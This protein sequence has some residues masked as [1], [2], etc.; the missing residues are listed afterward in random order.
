MSANGDALQL[1]FPIELGGDHDADLEV[2]ARS[3]DT[4]QSSSEQLLIEMFPDQTSALLADW[5]RVLNITPGPDDPVQL[6]RDRI[7][8]MLRAK[9]GL[10][11]SYF[12]GLAQTLG[13]EIEIEEPV[14]FMAGWGTAGDDIFASA[15]IS[16]WGVIIKNQP[17]YAFLAGESVAGESLCWWNPQAFLEDLI[18]ELKPAHTTVYFIYV[19]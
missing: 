5:E 15:V 3:L 6:R 8:R 7:V 9:G 4:A 14:P 10:S 12:I 18:K 2:D 1:L 11:R 17:I 13:Y 16:Q 19:G